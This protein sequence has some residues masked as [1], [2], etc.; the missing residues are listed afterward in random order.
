MIILEILNC[1]KKAVNEKKRL[2]KIIF[3]FFT[4][5][6]THSS[7]IIIYEDLQNYFTSYSAFT[8]NHNS[9]NINE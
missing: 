8:V 6:F 5:K 2:L 9:K 3:P 4:S 1:S 7:N